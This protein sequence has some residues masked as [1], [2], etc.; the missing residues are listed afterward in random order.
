MSFKS[1]DSGANHPVSIYINNNILKIM[2]T[3]RYSF[4]SVYS[5]ICDSTLLEGR[6]VNPDVVVL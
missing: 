2:Q 3:G 6:F 5:P 4:S 1:Y